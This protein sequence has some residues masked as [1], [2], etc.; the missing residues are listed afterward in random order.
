MS[1]QTRLGR[2]GAIAMPI[3]PFV[4]PGSPGFDVS[5]AHVLPP[6]VVLNSAVPG[7][8]LRKPHGNRRSS[9]VDAYSTSGWL[10]SMTRSI[11][12]ACSLRKS[13]FSQDFPPFFER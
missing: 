8:A 6:S 7:P 9:S 13:T 12:P 3:R 10:A 11:A 2:D 4:P 5:S 1:A